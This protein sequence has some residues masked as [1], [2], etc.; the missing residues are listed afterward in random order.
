MASGLRWFVGG[1]GRGVFLVFFFLHLLMDVF[2]K[3]SLCM[4]SSDTT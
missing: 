3:I 2:E 4:S 1:F